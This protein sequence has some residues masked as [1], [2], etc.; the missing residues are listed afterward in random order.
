M[1][2]AHTTPD[3]ARHAAHWHSA[4][5]YMASGISRGHGPSENEEPE[6]PEDSVR[7][8]AGIL[9]RDAVELHGQRL[10]LAAR[11]PPPRPQRRVGL[12]VLPMPSCNVAIGRLLAKLCCMMS[13]LPASGAVRLT[14]TLSICFGSARTVP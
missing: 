8:L 12:D 2:G 7:L 1:A 5:L 9:K 10:E 13:L 4:L 6:E 11:S 3:R 14:V